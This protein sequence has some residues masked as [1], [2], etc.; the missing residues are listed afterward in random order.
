MH[1]KVAR[2]FL[3]GA[4]LALAHELYRVAAANAYYAMFWAVQAVLQ[5]VGVVREEWLHGGLQ[6]AFGLEMIKKRALPQELRGQL[7][8]PKQVAKLLEGME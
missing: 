3:R 6:Q 2:E 1:L 8:S 4:E 5:R 7:L